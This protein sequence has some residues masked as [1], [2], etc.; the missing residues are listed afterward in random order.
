MYAD[1]MDFFD[2][3]SLTICSYW[4]LHLKSFLNDIHCLHR[5]DEYK[6]LLVTQH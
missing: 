2:S 1:S 4:L 6:L 5:A 3:L